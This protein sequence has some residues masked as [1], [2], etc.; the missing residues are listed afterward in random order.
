MTETDRGRIVRSFLERRVAT[1]RFPGVAWWVE[2]RGG[3]VSRGAVGD[4]V[5][6]P[7]CT[8]LTLD[9]PF[10][11]ASL[12]KPLSTAL[13][14]VLLEGEGALDLEAPIG[15]TIEEMRDSAFGGATSIELATH[16]AGLPPWR[17]LYLRGR[18]RESYIAQIAQEVRAV[19]KGETLY[20]DLGYILLG[21]AIERSA[22]QTLDALFSTRIAKP[23]G[24]R[25]SGFAT[26][27]ASFAD[28][29]ATE[30]G[31][32]YEKRLAGA[33][34][35]DHPWRESVI[36]GAVHDGNAFALGG[37][38]GHAGLFG[39]VADVGSLMREI[40]RPRVLRLS[41][42]ARS[43][44]LGSTDHASG[45]TV[46]FVAAR[47]A[48]AAAGILPDD[49]RGHTGFTG[50]SVWLDPLSGESFVMLTNRVHPVADGLDFD[51]VRRGFHRAA[52]HLLSGAIGD[53]L[54]Q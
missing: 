47:A 30:R 38:A 25:R 18:D 20:S 46:G 23:L 3:V 44:M 51:R 10:D 2:G 43:R 42:L 14:L 28:A 4:A 19:A 7:R 29:A 1:G 24:L 16:R 12:T 36:R 5:V 11:L 33:A 48:R 52:T 39:T 53:E 35:A 34:G 40:L 21:I 50:T 27:P 8:P 13:L 41:H 49:A 17:P 31:N 45:R 6:E 37:V 54:L 32:L 9:T 22:G 15:E 26:E